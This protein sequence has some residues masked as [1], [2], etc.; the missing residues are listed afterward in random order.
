MGILKAVLVF[1]RA[2]LVAKVNLAFENLA[3]RQQLAVCRQSVK[4]PKLCLRD[5]VFW[6][7]LSRSMSKRLATQSCHARRRASSFGSCLV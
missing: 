5:R 6:V 3:L 4:R 2:M 1:L 7:W